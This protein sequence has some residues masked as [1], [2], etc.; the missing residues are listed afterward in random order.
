M[1]SPCEITLP[2][3]LMVGKSHMRGQNASCDFLGGKRTIVCI[4]QNWFGGLRNCDWSG[5]CPFLL[6]R[7]TGREQ[8]EV[9]KSY[10]RWGCPNPFFG[11]SFKVC[12][13]PPLSFPHPFVLL[14][15]SSAPKP[16]RFKTQRLQDTNAAKSQTLAS[17]LFAMGPVQ[18]S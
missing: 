14:L 3:L 10:H 6:R 9:F 7:M 13:P 11:R 12:F 4:L 8:R 17:E 5:L 18:F 1:H 16:Q 15:S 2:K